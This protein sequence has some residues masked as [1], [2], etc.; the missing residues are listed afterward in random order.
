MNSIPCPLKNSFNDNNS[1][2]LYLHAK[3]RTK[4]P[5]LEILIE[6]AAI[7]MLFPEVLIQKCGAAALNLED[8]V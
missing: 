2:G 7:G 5:Y 4:K 6:G 3:V 1:D 8:G